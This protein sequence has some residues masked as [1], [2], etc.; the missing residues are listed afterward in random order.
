[1]ADDYTPGTAQVRAY[2]VLA[3]GR[4]LGAER[5]DRWLAAHDAEV[6]RDEN[7]K[8][9]RNDPRNRSHWESTHG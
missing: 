8:A 1:M 2:F 7:A 6:R 4:R 3:H 5:F 9:W